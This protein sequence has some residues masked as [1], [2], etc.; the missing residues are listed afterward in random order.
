MKLDEFY[1]KLRD[2]AETHPGAWYLTGPLNHRIRCH[3]PDGKGHIET[4]CPISAVIGDEFALRDPIEI[5]IVELALSRHDADTIVN[6][7]DN[8]LEEP[9]FSNSVRANMLAATGIT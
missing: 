2:H 6:S 1:I 7:S 8:N 5:A 9:T 4:H 3:T